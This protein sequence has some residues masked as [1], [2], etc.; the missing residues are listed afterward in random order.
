MSTLYIRQYTRLAHDESGH[1]IAAGLEP[2]FDATPLTI[3]GTSASV[4]IRSGTKFVRL[5][6]DVICNFVCSLDPNVTAT[7]NNAR[8]GA[9][10]TEFF[11]TSPGL[12]IAVIAGV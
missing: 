1:P 3:S 5:T 6:T 10:Q 11:G 8:M 9:G 4:A 2:G 7:A 12:Y